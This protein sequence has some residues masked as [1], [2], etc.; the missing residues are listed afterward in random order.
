MKTYITLILAVLILTSCESF[1]EEKPRD[2]I[3][4]ENFPASQSDAEMMLAGAMSTLYQERMYD[5]SLYFLAEASSDHTDPSATSGPRYDIGAFTYTADNEFVWRTWEACY[6]IINNT[7]IMIESLPNSQM[8][9]QS[10]NQY[11]SAAKF[12]RAFSYFHLVR[13]YG[14]VPLL[15]APVKDFTSASSMPRSPVADVYRFVLQDLEEAERFLPVEW[16][17][18]GV[19]RPD[20]GSCKSLL[21]EVYITAAGYPLK[22]QGMWSRAAAKAKEVIDMGKYS[23]MDD[24]ASLWL[25]ANR[26]NRESV[27]S[28]QNMTQTTNRSMMAVQTRPSNLP[29]GQAG[30][31]MWH[32]NEQ[33][34]NTFDEEDDRK[35][36]SF[37][38]EY[39]GMTYRNFPNAQPYIRKYFDAGRENF[40][41]FNRRAPI[42]IPIFR[43]AEILLFHAEAT[44]EAN[45]GPTAEAY[46]SVNQVRTRAGLP[47]LPPGLS[48]GDFREA[49]RRERSFELAFECK[50]RYDL[51]RWETFMDVFSKYKLTKNNVKPYHVIYPVP[52]R[53]LLLNPNLG[54]NSGY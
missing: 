43:Y 18:M 39:K 14:E 47:A 9:E 13:L 34:L 17:G 51:V 54:Q 26:N 30:W 40:G 4:P 41:E 32:S 44:N 36:A 37:L 23:L 6:I 21:A 35:A 45:G 19:G 15:T 27:M 38:T 50:R 7:N 2:F 25:V 3:S 31:G 42:Y 12:L 53:E 11:I 52:Q 10:I 8:P 29:G 33:F 28:L 1:L 5:R 24:F 22:D 49:V 48:Q 16:A 20:L 46:H